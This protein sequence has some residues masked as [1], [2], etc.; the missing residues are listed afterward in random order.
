MQ[1]EGCELGWC[2]DAEAG[3]ESAE[4]RFLESEAT[5]AVG[6]IPLSIERQVDSLK[7]GQ[8]VDARKRTCQFVDGTSSN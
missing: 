2:T 4:N 1:G 3:R 8:L 7:P 5:L 6:I